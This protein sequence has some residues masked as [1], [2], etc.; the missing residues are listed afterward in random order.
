MPGLKRIKVTAIVTSALLLGVF[1][2]ITSESTSDPEY[3]AEIENWHKLR[4]DSL[5]GVTGYLNLAG[6]Y[7]MENEVNS[8]GS[9]SANTVVF[10]VK[11][12]PYLGK[13]IL[14]Q[15]SLWFIQNGNNSVELSGDNYAD[16]TLIYVDGSIKITMS[17][18]D[19]HWYIIKRGVDYGIRLKDYNHP[20]LATFNHIDNYATDESWKVKATWEEYDEPKIVTVHN[21]VG[22]DLEMPVPGALHF[23]LSGNSYSLEPVGSIDHETLFIMVYDE[24]SGHETY[25]SG[26]YIDVPK[27][28]EE[29]ITYIDFNKAYNPPCAFTEFATCLFPHKANRMP[30]EI[31]AGEKYS[32]LH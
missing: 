29:G 26:R 27:F 17:S 13:I 10:P 22:M 18:G 5:K 15:D 19:L 24:T 8:F 14:K 12:E 1:S 2:C 16:T 23:E 31:L 3:I 21:Q 6:L 20:L 28:N 7:W 30:I 4:I 25:G 32:G 11:A 9:D